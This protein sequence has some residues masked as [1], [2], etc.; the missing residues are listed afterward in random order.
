MVLRLHN[1]LKESHERVFLARGGHGKKCV[2]VH[3]LLKDYAQVKPSFFT[4]KIELNA[5]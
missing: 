5:E 2:D 3:W 1:G 4:V